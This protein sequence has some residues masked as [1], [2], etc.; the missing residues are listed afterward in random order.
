MIFLEMFIAGILAIVI[1]AIG[2]YTG[3]KHYRDELDKQSIAD[4]YEVFRNDYK[5]E[6]DEYW[7]LSI[8]KRNFTWIDHES[9]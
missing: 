4:L 5:Y 3:K 8:K 1:F 9:T 7:N 2:Y 6:E